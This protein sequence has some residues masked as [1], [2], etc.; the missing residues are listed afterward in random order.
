MGNN[1]LAKGRWIIAVSG[2]IMMVLLGTVY[3]WSVFK[4]PLMESHG[5]TG[6]QVGM[7]FT[8]AIFCIGLSAAFGGKFVDKAGTRK[9]ASLAAI[10][11]GIGT[12]LTGLADN[13]GNIWLLYL[14]YGIIAGIGNGLGYITPI[15]VLVRWFPDKRGLITGLC[16]MGFGFGAAILGQVAPLVIPSIGVS[17]TF[18]LFG[19]IYLIVLL[20]AAQKINNPPTG[21][22]APVEA[23][24]APSAVKESFDLKYALRMY[25]FYLLWL[26]LF[27][28]VT[29]GIA[30]ISN[31]SPMAQSQ[32]GL[33]AVTAGTIVFI[34]SLFNGFGRIFWAYL[35]DKI[36]RKSVFLL[37]LGTQIPLFI[38][39]PNI[40]S[41]VLFTILCCYVLACYGGGFATMPSFTT[42]TF[43]HKNIGSIYGKILLAWG[44]AGVV[45][46][47][48]MERIKVAT[49][50]FAVALYI[51]AGMLAIGFVLALLYR[52]PSIT[53][54]KDA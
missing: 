32:I 6:P 19:I 49:D 11:F 3:G 15:A 39:L 23:K 21:W 37:I 51:A 36:G 31:L 29:S 42:D 28:N 33:T 26:I 43:G 48:L 4:K 46:P 10:L 14:G 2:I 27:I 13:I 12:L 8:I 34:T 16:V 9:V 25:Q 5:W 54:V 24:K 44:I 53:E 45:G 18:Y 52:R 7:A 22:V 47:I 30:L 41:A 50:S 40:S 35:S 38:I 17:G 1:T 20:V